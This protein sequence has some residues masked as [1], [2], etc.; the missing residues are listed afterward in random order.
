[1]ESSA[2][3]WQGTIFFLEERSF[4]SAASRN[5]LPDDRKADKPE[6]NTAPPTFD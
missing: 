5:T 6:L 2:T 3:R 1:M 4:L